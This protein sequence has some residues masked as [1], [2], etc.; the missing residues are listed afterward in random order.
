MW[1]TVLARFRNSINDRSLEGPMTAA[2]RAPVSTLRRPAVH[3]STLVRSDVEHTFDVFVTTI[4]DWWP[5]DQ[6]SAGRERARTVTIEPRTGGR[7]YE[8]WDDGSEHSWAEITEWDR[9]A[10]FTIAWNGTPAPTEVELAFTALG[11]SLT[12][13]SVEHR[14]WDQLT[15][16]QLAEDCAAPGGYRAGQYDRGWQRVLASFTASLRVP[17]DEGGVA[18]ITDDYMRSSIS[19]NKPYS[20]VLLNKGPNYGAPGSDKIIW[21]H[22]R[23]NFAL[24]ANGVLAIVCPVVDDSERCGIGIFNADPAAAVRL[25]EDDPGVQ[26]G[27][28]TYEV[29][30]VRSFPGDSLPA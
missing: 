12:R 27:V 15:D 2:N 17:Y 20:F 9:P 5:L 10:G 14:G 24:R 16:E 21:E 8:T 18:E 28:F 30:P 7:V 1:R 26:A 3:A 19:L 6:V 13:V 25:L 23:R 22:G 11:P 4:G 29:H